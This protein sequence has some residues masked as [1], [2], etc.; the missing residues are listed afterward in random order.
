MT[1][2]RINQVTV[3]QPQRCVH[4]LQTPSTDLPHQSGKLSRV[5]VRYEA[6]MP[7]HFKCSLI[8]CSYVRRSTEK[9]TSTTQPATGTPYPQASQ[10]SGTD[11]PVQ[12]TRI[13]AFG[14]DYHEPAAPI[15]HAAVQVDPQVVT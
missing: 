12:R 3:Y 2:G 7:P 1:T 8:R 11:L 10:V 13:T 5:G 4:L 14:G 9:C 6:K 15:R